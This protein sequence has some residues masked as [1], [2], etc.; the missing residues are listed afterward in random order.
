MNRLLMT[1]CAI[2]F[3]SNLTFAQEFK[4]LEALVCK[5][6]DA[7]KSTVEVINAKTGMTPPEIIDTINTKLGA[8]TCKMRRMMVIE[9]PRVASVQSEGEEYDIEQITVV[10][11]CQ[12]GFC[13]FLPGEREVAYVLVDKIGT[14]A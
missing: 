4:P 8:D 6:V 14:K 1:S 13:I 9:G 5:S 10:G 3:S 2:L 7:M 11:N 12:G